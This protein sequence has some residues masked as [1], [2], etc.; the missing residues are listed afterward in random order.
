MRSLTCTAALLCG[1][2]SS[3]S[4]NETSQAAVPVGVVQAVRKPVT[5]SLEFVGRIEAINRVEIRARVKGY[6]D[7]VLFTDGQAV[8]EGAPLY[9]I[10][11]GLFQAAVEQAQ[12][13][14]ER[15]QAAYTLAQLQTQRAVQL[16]SRGNGTAVD[17]D[18]AV[19][20]EAQTKGGVLTEEANLTTARINL[21][22]TDITSPIAGRI[23][24]TSLTKGN[25]VGPES[26]P[27]TT[28][29][30][31]DPMYV[32]FP[33]SQRELLRAQD[34]QQAAMLTASKFAFVS[35]TGPSTIRS[36]L[37]TSLA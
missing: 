30:S 29:V 15:S 6:L 31:Q 37:L 23:G 21:G 36:A 7:A 11:K 19:A 22:Y 33:V 16:F 4:A 2:V 1:F 35:P 27:L 34:S 10:E 25:V 24:R 18:R 5:N 28:I 20:Q 12:G 3:A 13:A 32:T 17:R 26:G 14:L 9:Q 8:K